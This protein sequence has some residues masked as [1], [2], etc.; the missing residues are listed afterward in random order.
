MRIAETKSI[1]KDQ[2]EN[3]WLKWKSKTDLEFTIPEKLEVSPDDK[4]PRS[5]E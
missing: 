4:S 3:T 2:S 1:Y 5:I